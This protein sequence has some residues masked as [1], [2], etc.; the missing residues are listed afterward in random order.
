[1]YRSACNFLLIPCVWRPI[2]EKRPSIML[3][4]IWRIN[5]TTWRS[6]Y[7][8]EPPPAMI[9]ELLNRQ[10]ASTL[11]ILPFGIFASLWIPC[12]IKGG[13][14]TQSFVN[15][16]WTNAPDW[17]SLPWRVEPTPMILLSVFPVWNWTLHILKSIY[18]HIP[19]GNWSTSRLR[20]AYLPVSMPILAKKT[21]CYL[22]VLY[23]KASKKPIHSA[24]SSSVP[25]RMAIWKKC[26]FPALQ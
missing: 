22:P 23:L 17:A 9:P 14:W 4:Q 21:S 12:C 7:Y 25:V 8:R 2:L 20:A 1:M 10:R 3:K 15:L 13:I 18:L 5:T 24:R 16:P 6:S 26:R 11:L 19:I